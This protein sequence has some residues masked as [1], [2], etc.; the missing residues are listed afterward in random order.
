[1]TV[2]I[3]SANTLVMG[4]WTS[5][6]LSFYLSTSP[7]HFL[8]ET[9]LRRSSLLKQSKMH[10]VRRWFNLQCSVLFCFFVFFWR[11]EFLCAASF[12]DMALHN[13]LSHVALQSFSPFVKDVPPSIHTCLSKWLAAS[14]IY[15]ALNMSVNFSTPSFIIVCPR[16]FSRLFLILCIS[17]LFFGVFFSV[18]FFFLLCSFTLPSLRQWNS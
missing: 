15:L 9:I 11:I 10:I 4:F 2:T 14:A 18:I 5:S 16:N 6:W 3:R 1:M 13:F 7:C 8:L 12:Q 17:F